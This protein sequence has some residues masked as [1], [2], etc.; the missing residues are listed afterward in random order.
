MKWEKGF[1]MEI[2]GVEACTSRAAE[3]KEH[4]TF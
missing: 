3:M 4:L 2:V 1:L